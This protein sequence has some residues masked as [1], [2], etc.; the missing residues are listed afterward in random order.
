MKQ[1]W[2]V[3]NEQRV[4]LHL[5]S[6]VNVLGK[7]TPDTGYLSALETQKLKVD[8]R[9]KTTSKYETMFPDFYFSASNNSW[10]CKTC[11]NFATGTGLRAFIEK[12]GGFGDYPGDRVALHLNSK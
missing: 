10:Y 4:D 7:K 3:Q 5:T 12:P 11:P 6:I 8:L 2:N 9:V 1:I